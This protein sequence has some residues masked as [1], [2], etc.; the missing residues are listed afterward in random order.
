MCPLSPKK[1]KAVWMTTAFYKMV[2]QYSDSDAWWNVV[3][4][5]SLVGVQQFGTSRIQDEDSGL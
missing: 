5:S 4:W 1:R 3:F 2:A